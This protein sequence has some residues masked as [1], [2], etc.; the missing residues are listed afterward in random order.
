MGSY[1]WKLNR[2]L[3]L[4]N[5]NINFDACENIVRVQLLGFMGN[6]VIAPSTG[7]MHAF[8]FDPLGSQLSH[9][10]KSRYLCSYSWLND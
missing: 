1:S 3:G 8:C 7:Y 9:N 6:K 2:F 4:D 10:Y 5:E